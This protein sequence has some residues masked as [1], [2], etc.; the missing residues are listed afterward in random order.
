MSITFD[1]GSK[2]FYLDGKG[3][4]YAFFINDWD[5]AEHLY[6]GKT[7]A[8]DDLRYIREMGG[9]SAQ[10][11]VPGEVRPRE[12]WRRMDSYHVFPSE[13]TF[14]GS[15]DYRESAVHVE[16][17]QG[18][19][20][21]QL[22]YAG[23][24]ILEEKPEI[25]GMPSMKGGQTLVVHLADRYNGLSCDL[26]YTVYDDCGVIARRAV[27]RN[28][29][30]E[31]LK[32]HRA[33]SFA[34]S[35]PGQDYDCIS[36]YGTWARERKIDKTPL[37]HGVFSIDSKRTTSSAVLNPFLALARKGATEEW[38]DVYGVN[39]VYSSSFVLKAEGINDGSTLLTGGI[40]D[41]DFSWLLEPG[42]AL[43]TPEAV[44][45]Y[46]CEGIGGMSR[47]YH[48]AYRS[49]LICS[50]FDGQ[51]RPL[52]INNWEGTYFKFNTEKLKAIADG[53]VGTGIDTFVLDDGWFGV[54][55]DEYSGLGD[56]F[57][58]TDKLPGGL[59]E[60]IDHVHSL[61]MKFGLWFEPEMV[62]EDSELYR[63]HPDWTIAA[64]G[65][66]QCRTRL[67]LMLDLTRQEVRDYIVESVNKVLRENAIDY[68]KWDYNRNVT[69]SWS[70][71]RDAQR[72]AEF[73][74][75]YALGVY[76]LFERI[77]NANPHIFFEGCAS[78]GSRFDPGVL[79]Y[80]PQ[81]WTSDDTDAEE[82]TQ[83]QYGTS[84]VYPLC[85]MSCHVSAVPNHQTGRTT[86]LQTRTD[87]AH[88]GPTGYELDSSSFTDEDRKGI[89]RDVAAFREVEQLLYTGDLYRTENPMEGNFFGFTVVSKDKKEA[90]L[91]AYRRISQANADVENVKVRGLAPDKRYYIP[92]LD[93]TL[94]GSTL[95][96]IGLPAGF[97]RGDYKTL[98]YHFRE[99]CV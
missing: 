60:I 87:I 49:H 54:R 32:L 69:E 47:C 70:L 27:Y 1:G 74:H 12:I 96:S 31:N 7:I 95:M 2:T 15:G 97:K 24:E 89:A 40:H 85:C 66:P 5:Y 81:I 79:A 86:D 21:S 41:F 8:H 52:V 59:A 14:F 61:G 53:V 42:E 25:S 29:G 73:A 34:M 46:S 64:P 37:H 17:T 38:G 39:L 72:Q 65:R 55:N 63:A 30:G 35:L 48:D 28:S 82:R 22:L 91:T 26:Y 83:I 19:R 13:L 67:Q 4:T 33:Y 94:G 23:H 3:I 77:V 44:L 84:M 68:V 78:G 36:L 99:V 90:F 43:E 10:A 56:W 92:E 80:F 16:T 20:V 11:V 88:L 57:V 45:A 71:G 98:T 18:D 75:R 50:R 6:F 9:L 93:M 76:D 62:S 58:N 51:P